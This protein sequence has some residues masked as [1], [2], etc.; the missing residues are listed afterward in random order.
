MNQYFSIAVRAAFTFVA[1]LLIQYMIPYYLLA[2]SGIGIGY[3]LLKA[4]GDRVM[5]LG[6]I[7]GSAAFGVF[8]L[9]FGS[10]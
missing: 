6:L 10:V 1:C 5:G 3:F 8:A 4:A 9:L 7:I 2:F